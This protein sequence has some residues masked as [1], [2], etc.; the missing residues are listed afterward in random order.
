[1]LDYFEVSVH[2]NDKHLFS[3]GTR[4]ITSTPQLEVILRLFRK[5]FPSFEGYEVTHMHWQCADGLTPCAESRCRLPIP[6]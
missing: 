2:H 4:S 3:T 1:M 5:K 6:L